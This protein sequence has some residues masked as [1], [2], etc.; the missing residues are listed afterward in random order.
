MQNRCG[1]IDE[2]IEASRYYKRGMA[3][4]IISERPFSSLFKAKKQTPHASHLTPYALRFT[5]HTLHLTP[6]ASLI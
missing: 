4:K 2:D 6:H 3:K 1:F 5:L